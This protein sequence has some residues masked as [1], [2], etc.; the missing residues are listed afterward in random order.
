[1][2]IITR[3]VI[4]FLNGEKGNRS[5]GEEPQ[6]YLSDK[7]GNYAIAILEGGWNG[8]TFVDE[9]MHC[10]RGSEDDLKKLQVGTMLQYS[11]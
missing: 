11:A 1:M 4:G 7:I 9:G 2:D 6:V 5:R 3:K 8:D 10:P